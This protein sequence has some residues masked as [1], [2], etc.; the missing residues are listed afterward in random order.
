[1]RTVRCVVLVKLKKERKYRQIVVCSGLFKL[2][3]EIFIEDYASP[4]KDTGFFCHD[5]VL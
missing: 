5:N 4:C 2:A 1:M 3:F